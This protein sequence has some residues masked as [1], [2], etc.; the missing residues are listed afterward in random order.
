MEH[1]D[2][3]LKSDVDADYDDEEEHRHRALLLAPKEAE[4]THEEG[5]GEKGIGQDLGFALID[6]AQLLT[7]EP[8]GQG[9]FLALLDPRARTCLGLS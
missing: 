6:R 5:R 2:N 7:R 8:R 4:L 1:L 9:T 3:E